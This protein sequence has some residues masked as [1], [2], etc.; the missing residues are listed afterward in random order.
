LTGPDS[1]TLT[2]ELPQP[3]TIELVRAQE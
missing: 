2:I 1:M 3:I